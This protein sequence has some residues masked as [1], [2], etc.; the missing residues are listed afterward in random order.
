MHKVLHHCRYGGD[1]LPT[2][3]Q[4]C[5]PTRAGLNGVGTRLPDF[6]PERSHEH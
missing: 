5:M 4:K 2:P 3:A 6:S 1:E